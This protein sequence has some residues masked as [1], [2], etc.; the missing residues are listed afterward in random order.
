MESQ[1]ESFIFAREYW[2]GDSRDGGLVNGDGY[3]FFKMLPK[4]L[5]L[6][7]FE[8]YE[9]EEGLEVVTPLPEMQNV[10]WIEDFGFGDLDDLDRIEE[11]EFHRI[12]SLSSQRYPS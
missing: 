8:L 3:H 10:S 7:A 6:E 11:R 9:N 2:T 5:I 1:V 12:K 4:G